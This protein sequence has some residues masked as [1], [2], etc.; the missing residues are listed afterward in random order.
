[1][2]HVQPKV[3][4]YKRARFVT[5]LPVE[6]FYT[7]AHYWLGQFAGIWRIG[8]TKFATRMLGESVDF[9]IEAKPGAH[10]VAGQVV[11]W[12]EGFKAVSDLFSIV[13]GDFAGGNPA[14]EH[15]LTLVNRDPYGAGWL[16]AVR[17][18]PDPTCVPAEAYTRI[19]DETIDKLLEQGYSTQR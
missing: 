16:Y 17:G 10:L 4:E 1:M 14:L 11:G 12:I 8:L 2:D 13:E 9:G 3:L 6:Y 19:L 15:D 7:P 18:N 5:Q